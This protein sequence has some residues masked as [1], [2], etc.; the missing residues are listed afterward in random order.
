MHTRVSH[1]QSFSRLK[2]Q[3]RYTNVLNRRVSTCRH[4]NTDE[5]SASYIYA[6]TGRT[7]RYTGNGR[8]HYIWV[9]F[10]VLKTSYNYTFLESC[11][12][13]LSN[14]ISHTV[15]NSTRVGYGSK[16]RVNLKCAKW[17]EIKVKPSETKWNKRVVPWYISRIEHKSG[18]PMSGH[19]IHTR[20]RAHPPN[21]GAHFVSHA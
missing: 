9:I 16:T 2:S 10:K 12:Y 7:W 19:D 1:D 13:P 8:N 18:M 5:H 15:P 3:W 17:H 11:V 14:S 20:T 21:A 4:I 6:C